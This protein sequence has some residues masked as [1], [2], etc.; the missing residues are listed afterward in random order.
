MPLAMQAG[1]K[2]LAFVTAGSGLGRLT[3]EDLVG[4]VD[5]HGLESRTFSSL[6]AARS[7]VAQV[8]VTR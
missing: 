8:A 4:L 2:R 3:I 7:W 1:L 6:P 5:D